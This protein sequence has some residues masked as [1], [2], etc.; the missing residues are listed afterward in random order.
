MNL[1]SFKDDH[2]YMPENVKKCVL[3]AQILFSMYLDCLYI[4]SV[5]QNKLFDNVKY[6]SNTVK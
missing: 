1:T 5:K 4:N 2:F 6:F 3:C